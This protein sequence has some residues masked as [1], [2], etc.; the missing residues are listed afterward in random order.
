MK[1]FK[2]SQVGRMIVQNPNM[3]VD[4]SVQLTNLQNAQQAIL[5]FTDLQDSI[6]QI[7]AN[8][9]E[10]ESKLDVGD[11]GIKKQLQNVLLQAMEK[12]NAYSILTHM[13][14]ISGVNSLVDRNQMS[15]VNNVILK[16][17]QTLQSTPANTEGAGVTTD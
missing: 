14:L 5:Y 1:I 7:N 4:N 9:D 10:L 11:I 15:Q 12:T 6:E 13:N 2:I 3:P 16:N 8:I 17:I